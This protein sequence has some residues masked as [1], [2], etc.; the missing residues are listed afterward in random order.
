MGFG[1]GFITLRGID[2]NWSGRLLNLSSIRTG[3][4]SGIGGDIGL[5]NIIFLVSGFELWLPSGIFGKNFLRSKGYK[6]VS[7]PK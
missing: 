4:E 5:I 7:E 2:Y 1:P 3:I 6:A